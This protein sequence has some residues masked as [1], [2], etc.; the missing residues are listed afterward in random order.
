MRRILFLAH[1]N[2]YSDL[3]S[4]TIHLLENVR[5]VFDMIIFISNSTLSPRTLKILESLSDSVRVRSNNGFD[6]AAWREGIDDFG[7]DAVGN[8]DNVTLMNTTCFGPV[9]PLLSIYES[10]ER[11]SDVDFWG[12]TNFREKIGRASCRERVF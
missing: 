1:H 4:S 7:W 9:Y 12:I 3:D 8:Y 11:K 2:N 6:F 10:M 5:E